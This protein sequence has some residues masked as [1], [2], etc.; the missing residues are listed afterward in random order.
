M[1]FIKSKQLNEG[2]YKIEHPSGLNIYVYPKE[3]YASTYAMFGTN[4]G[5]IDSVFKRAGKAQMIEVPE[6]VAHFLE[7]KLFEN[8]DGDAF[9]K[10]AKTG[11][12]ANAFTSFD[13]TC[14]LFSTTDNF[15]EAFEILLS[16]VTSPYF[17][18]ET[19][20]KEQGIIGQEISMYD[21]DPNWRVYFNLLSSLY[22][23]H[24]VKIDIAG[25][26]ETIAKI[27]PEILYECYNTFY[28]LGNMALAVVG[29]VNV[30]TIINICDKHLKKS[31][32]VI[33]ERKKTE[34]PDYAKQNITEQNLEVAVPL[35]MFG[36]KLKPE[37]E[38]MSCK[39]TMI[40]NII[41]NIISGKTSKLYTNLLEE[42]L[43]NPSFNGDVD[44]GRGFEMVIFSGES[45]D[46]KKIAENIKA[47]I[48]NL[49]VNGI[50]EEDFKINKKEMFGKIIKSFNDISFIASNLVSRHFE[51]KDLFEVFSAVEDI[52]LDEANKV[53]NEVFIEENSALSI[54]NPV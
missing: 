10:Y 50:S 6:G 34:E 24:P 25:S 45:Y 52:T 20:E 18:K 53:L 14:Y 38:Y 26:K 32:K 33:I 2:Y 44:N 43:I 19:V 39:K 7:H 49:A 23:N 5:S 12:S 9:S 35:F 27:T 47:E 8:E 48:K 31:E 40:L 30:D 4:Y 3:D 13:R 15:E 51:N 28:N 21:D 36:Y 17:T 22:H 1:N 46:P 42:G 11:A 16:F 37:E 54:I 41:L 29:N